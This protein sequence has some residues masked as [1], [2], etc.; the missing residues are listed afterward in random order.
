MRTASLRLSIIILMNNLRYLT[1]VKKD[2]LSGKGIYFSEFPLYQFGSEQMKVFLD[3]RNPITKNTEIEGMREINSSGIPTKMIA[4]VLE[5]F[6]DFD[7][8][9]NRSEMTVRDSITSQIS[10]RQQRRLLNKPEY[11]LSKASC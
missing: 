1:E 7:G 3:I 10:H 2:G 11:P 4:D 8:V 6:P 9:M 5:R